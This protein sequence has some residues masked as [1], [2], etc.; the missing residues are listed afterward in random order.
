MQ[1]TRTASEVRETRGKIV[2]RRFFIDVEWIA[3]EQREQIR[4]RFL[5]LVDKHESRERAKV[6]L[7]A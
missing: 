3:N 4:E 7:D 6:N 1:K 5:F 2:A